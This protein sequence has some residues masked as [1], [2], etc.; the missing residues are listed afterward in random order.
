MCRISLGALALAGFAGA[1]GAQTSTPIDR[2]RVDRAQPVAPA[3]AEEPA[4]APAAAIRIA[5]G[6]AADAAP[7][8]SVRFEGSDVPAIV[9]G[10]A[11]T[12]IG[13]P[14]SRATLQGLADA[15]SRAYGRSPVALFTIAI[16]EQDLASGDILVMVAEGHVEAVVLT[17][18]V[19]GRALELVTAYA[20]RLTRER[21]TSRR[22][23]ERHLS[24][25]RDIPGLTTRARLEMGD[26]PGGVRL[27]LALDYRRPT[28]SFS[29]DN[30]TT[31]LVRDGQV[32]ASARGYGLLREGDETQVNAAAS[33]DFD[34]YVYLGASHSTPVGREGTRLAGSVGYLVTRPAATGRTGEAVSFGLVLTHPL[35]RAYRRNLSLSFSF[36]GLD[37][38]NAAFGALIATERTRAL[39]AA[40]G[41]SELAERRT[42]S[43]G[44]TLSQGLGLFGADVAEVIGDAA[45]FKINGRA[46][47]DQAL[48]RRAVLRL[49]GAGQWTNDPLPA[50]ERFGVGG[51]EYGR[52]FETAVLGAD[53]GL[54]GLAELAWRPL[55]VPR[56]AGSEL[57]GFADLA[58]VRLLERPG[59][60]G[61]DFDLASAGGGVRF[62]W[63]DR[64]LLEL[65]YAR[66]VDRPFEAYAGDWRISVAWRLSLRP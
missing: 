46:A 36:D 55:R 22:V 27:I 37:S 49:R 57:Y 3:V 51:A 26:T 47:L 14:A 62:A 48:G 5:T 44:V 30:R 43:G 60:A 1:A 34:D 35:I 2:E 33:V 16:P 8:R 50:A 13:R 38:R 21:P 56:L 9:A 59:F 10:A 63:A 41:F 6:E 25:I 17:G 4:Q 28:L 45:F 39:R 7:I 58:A 53:R 29:F 20:D 61:Q 64:A 23:L 32:Q 65:E 18:E 19:E 42:L 54:A 15:M 12:F 40:A 24:L 52:A 11:R 66:V 31:R